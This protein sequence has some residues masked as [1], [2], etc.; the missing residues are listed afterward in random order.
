MKKILVT[1]AD[2]FIGSHLVE[3]LI[4]KNYQVKAL[5]FYNFSNSNG[6]L[7]HVDPKIKNKIVITKGDIRDSNY[8]LEITKDVDC[9][10]NLAA[11]IGIPYSYVAPNS[12]FETNLNG[13]LNI[14]NASNTNKI[15]K[16]IHTST[17]EV[18]GSGLYF[19]M[20]EK[21]PIKPQSPYAASKAAAD[22]L[23]E[24]YY[25]SFNTP[26]TIL[27]P[28]NVF[29]PR[30][31]MRAVI[32]TIITQLKDRLRKKIFIG[33]I[34]TVR[35]FNYVFDTILAFEK[36]INNNKILGKTINVGNGFDKSIEEIIYYLKNISKI[37]KPI[38]IDNQRIRNYKSEVLKLKSKNFLAKK[39][40]GWKAKYN[41]KHNFL[42]ALE[43]TLN[44]YETN[45]YLF[46]KNISNKY[47]I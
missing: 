25:K 16:I 1:G 11:L 5:V 42:K 22:H 43:Q 31:S 19:P 46:K 18:Y 32:P 14:L 36:A 44:W 2:G 35:E 28:F 12:Y 21:H 15:K 4:K 7:D 39:Y 30:Q 6:W 33:N 34:K 10:I 9:I 3:L 13:L 24:S 45:S 23:A 29:G 26:V 17:S 41:N 8:I 20:D 27:R 37:N 40:L 38:K 47:I